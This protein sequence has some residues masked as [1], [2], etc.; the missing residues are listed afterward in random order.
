MSYR[1]KDYDL[2]NVNGS[3]TKIRWGVLSEEEI[4]NMSVV[5]II[6]MNS[7]GADEPVMGGLFDRRMG[8]ID[9]KTECPTC[10]Q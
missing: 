6:Q 4:V 10:K 8:V 9:K 2:K 3:I 1:F 7:Y 5:D